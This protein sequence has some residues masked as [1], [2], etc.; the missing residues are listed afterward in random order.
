M[1]KLSYDELA[2]NSYCNHILY[3]EFRCKVPFEI[4][5]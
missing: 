2:L 1:D 4:F 3:E 5:F